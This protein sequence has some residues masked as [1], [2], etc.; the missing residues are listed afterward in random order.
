MRSFYIFHGFIFKGID[1]N[2]KVGLSNMA[3]HMQKC[4]IGTYILLSGGDGLAKLCHN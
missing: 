2:N 1:I 4:N 3:V